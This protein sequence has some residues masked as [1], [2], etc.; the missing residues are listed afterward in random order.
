MCEHSHAAIR[1]R[2]TNTDITLFHTQEI[3]LG[4]KLSQEGNVSVY[5]ARWRSLHVVAKVIT[6]ASCLYS[7]NNSSYGG[8][9]AAPEMMAE[10]ERYSMLRHP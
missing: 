1:A 9:G 5:K 2:N 3:K 10:M 8:E 4:D 6:N 7:K